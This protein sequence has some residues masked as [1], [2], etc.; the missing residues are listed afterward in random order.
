[1]R[2]GACGD[3]RTRIRGRI[4]RIA[5]LAAGVVGCAAALGAVALREVESIPRGVV[6]AP[7]DDAN[8]AFNGKVGERCA[9]SF[10]IRNETGNEIRLFSFRLNDT[11]WEK[12]SDKRGV[13]LPPIPCV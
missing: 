7:S 3:N 8:L 11:D 10:T 12:I 2:R 9:R 6:F 4:R 5:W 13:V 1:M